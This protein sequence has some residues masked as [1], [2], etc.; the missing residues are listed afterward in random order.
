MLKFVAGLAF[1]A[2]L[3]H[4]GEFTDENA[5]Q[6][7]D[8][9]KDDENLLWFSFHPEHVKEHVEQHTPVLTEVAKNTP[10]MKFVW[11]NTAELEDHAR[12][13]LGCEEFPCVSLVQPSAEDE[14]MPD[15][16]FTRT[17]PSVDANSVSSFLQGVKN[18][19]ITPH[20]HPDDYEEHDYDDEEDY[21]N[22]DEDA[23]DYDEEEY[24][25]D[26]EYDAPE[27]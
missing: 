6:Y 3:P 27:M 10:N 7:Y 26:G 15:A 19:E 4:F 21:E 23:E 22:Y 5:E 8:N 12:E 18:N 25:H 17:L 1:A 14:D 9:L 13:N 24:D 20:I 11:Y 2:E 16:V